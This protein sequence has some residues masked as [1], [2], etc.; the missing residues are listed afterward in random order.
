MRF[1]LLG[2]LLLTQDPVINQPTQGATIIQIPTTVANSVE[3]CLE[4]SPHGLYYCTTIGS[5]REGIP[6]PKVARN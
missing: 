4:A 6:A 1:A 2:L 3:L 5:L